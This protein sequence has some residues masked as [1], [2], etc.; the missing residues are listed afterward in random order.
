M[1]KLRITVGNKSYDVIVEDLTEPD[2]YSAP[3]ARAVSRSPSIEPAPPVA[4]APTA[5]AKP[6]LPAEGGSVTSPM[7]GAIKSVLVKQ[8]DSVKKAQPLVILEA[9]K[10]EN[11]IT[12]PVDGSVARIDVAEGDSV[13]EGQILLVLE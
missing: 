1:K 2:S 3:S 5:A 8:G 9:M 7:A 13:G 4:A 6:S 10:M 11:Q 12:A